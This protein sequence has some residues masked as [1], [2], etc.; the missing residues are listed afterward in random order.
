MKIQSLGHVVIRVRD[1]KR[2]EDFYNGI[3]GLPIVARLEKY[4][5]TF[6]SLGDHHDFAVAAMGDD[7]PDAPKNAP[8][9]E[10]V[11]FRIG[12]NL[13][14][15]REAKAHLEAAGLKLRLVEHEV[16]QSIYFHDPDGNQVEV[17]VDGTDK[18]KEDPSLVAQGGPLQL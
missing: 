6:F 3:L 5:M 17:Y 2:S 8:G 13:D 18:W 16:S 4:K 14:E 12:D 10:H 9:L 7:A 1:Q 11:A 15:L